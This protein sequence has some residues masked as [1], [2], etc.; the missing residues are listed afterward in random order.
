MSGYPGAVLYWF[1]GAADGYARW[2]AAHPGELVVMYD[3]RLRLADS[4][5]RPDGPANL[6]GAEVGRRVLHHAWC[7]TIMTPQDERQMICGPGAELEDDFRDEDAWPCPD[8][9]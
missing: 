9:F 4:H 7:E 2:L 1:V 5:L 8:C 6:R 3:R